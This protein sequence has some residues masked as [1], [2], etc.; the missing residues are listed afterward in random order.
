MMV[1]ATFV[2]SRVVGMRRPYIVEEERG[3][4]LGLQSEKLQV[5]QPQKAQDMGL[6]LMSRTWV[7]NE[8][9]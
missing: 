5:S 2:H 1:M 4:A 3:V 9:R 7:A 8:G 6:A